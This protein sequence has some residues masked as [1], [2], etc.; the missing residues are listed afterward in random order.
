MLRTPVLVMIFA[1][2]VLAA[3]A[4]KPV[5]LGCDLPRYKL[6]VAAPV[7]AAESR[8]TVPT[9]EAVVRAALA[10]PRSAAEAA[11]T[12]PSLLFLSGGSENGAFGA[13][14][15]D[16]WAAQSPGKR[17]PAFRVVTGVSTGALQAITV[18]TGRTA[19][20]VDG[21]TIDRE[22]ELLQPLGKGLLSAVRNGSVATLEPLRRVLLP[23]LL[24]DALLTDTARAG[25][26][27]AEGGPGRKLLV[28]VVN[29]NSGDA[30]II[31]LTEIARHWLAAR[32]P[33]RA[34]AKSCLIEALVASSSAP[35]AAA[36]VY[37][38]NVQ[39]TDGGSR[40]GVFYQAATDAL[41]PVDGAESFP[42]N[43]TAYLI[44]NGTLA[45]EPYCARQ[46][47][48]DGSCPAAGPLRDWSLL[49]LAQRSVSVLTN[50]VYRFSA[51]LVRRRADGRLLFEAA[52]IEPAAQSFVFKPDDLPGEATERTCAAWKAD[53]VRLDHPVQFHRRYMRCLIAYG[54]SQA[55][56]LGWGLT[57]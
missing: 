37:I 21:Y 33:A 15:L 10:Q 55:V 46:P 28:G 45:I 41:Q 34:A 1:G 11:A 29:M 12:S 18:F 57:R 51:D 13:G 43:G 31:D 26:P 30:E 3:C 4:H 17:L 44:V 49:S 27:V 24:D 53:D 48:A 2:G 42:P 39:Y 47:H 19:A 22:G 9:Y 52:L 32:G 23:R 35:L 20:T 25:V 7:G 36:P 14:L 8:S 56:A 5:S 16:Q 40:F 38:D 6:G 50:Q 54:R